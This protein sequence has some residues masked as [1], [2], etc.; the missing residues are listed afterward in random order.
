MSEC[1]HSHDRCT[2]LQQNVLPTRVIDV[3]AED[4][5]EPHLVET[6]GEKG[7]WVALSHR[8]GGNCSLRTLGENLSDRLTAI[9]LQTFPKTFRDAVFITRSLGLRY[10]WIDALC[11]IQDDWK[12]WEREAALMTNVYKNC[13]VT[14]ATAASPN[15]DHGIFHS[16]PIDVHPIM[17]PMKTSSFSGRAMIYP[18]DLYPWYIDQEYGLYGSQN[19]LRHRGWILQG[20]MLSPRTIYFAKEQIYWECAAGVIAEAEL[21]FMQDSKILDIGKCKS[22]LLQTSCTPVP[23]IKPDVA[24]IHKRWRELIGN[25]SLRNLTQVK[26]R[27]P[28]IA[29]VAAAFSDL[30]QD[31]T[32]L[33]GIWEKDYLTGLAWSVYVPSDLRHELGPL[34]QCKD[35]IAPSWSW[36]SVQMGAE[37][38]FSEPDHWQ[39]GRDVPTLEGVS[40]NLRDEKHPFGSINDSSITLRGISIRVN[41]NPEDSTKLSACSSP[42][43]VV[44]GR[45]Q[46]NEP[47][48][49]DANI[50]IS[51]DGVLMASGMNPRICEG[52]EG[53]G[54]EVYFQLD[55]DPPKYENSIKSLRSDS[56]E[57]FKLQNNVFLVLQQVMGESEAWRRTG[58]ACLRVAR[59]EPHM[60]HIK[61]NVDSE[62]FWT[63]LEK[64]A[65]VKTV[66]IV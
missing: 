12:D 24:S 13:R 15:S 6:R 53:R 61:N 36:A 14:I 56:I 11:I 62:R 55:F 64:Q 22:F 19:L 21:D 26:D 33:A 23:Q 65:L 47:V 42:Y 20:W 10:L 59:G 44:K 57:L 48:D 32:Y 17:I 60:G 37:I 8:W 5:V 25:Y 63:Y 66:K 28:A 30:L 58:R 43:L 2:K 35:Y 18:V 52:P 49:W 3:G 7:T 50:K 41:L 54:S 51:N 45:Y 39:M 46:P 1:L 9:P 40:N 31:D 16:R 27:L 38:R 34:N 29:G 4:S